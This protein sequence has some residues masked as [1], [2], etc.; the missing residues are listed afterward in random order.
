MN[1]APHCSSV[2]EIVG[3]EKDAIY[4]LKTKELSEEFSAGSLYVISGDVEIFKFFRMN[5]FLWLSS[6][7]FFF[8]K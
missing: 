2:T 5:V 6:S 7:P 8:P 1:G 4:T 3:F